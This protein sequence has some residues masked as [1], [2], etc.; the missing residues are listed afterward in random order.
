MG[1]ATETSAR[2]GSRM[3]QKSKTGQTVAN[4]LGNEIKLVRAGLGSFHIVKENEEQRGLTTQNQRFSHLRGGAVDR[5]PTTSFATPQKHEP[6]IVHLEPL[7]ARLLTGIPSGL[8]DGQC[9]LSL[10][11]VLSAH[12]PIS[13]SAYVLICAMAVWIMVPFDLCYF[14]MV[15]FPW[16]AL[17]LPP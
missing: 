10:S 15:G 5:L 8:L 9:L 4:H 14:V 1:Q 6:F 2:W 13:L 12:Q 17:S 11:S 16:E 7:D 3:Q